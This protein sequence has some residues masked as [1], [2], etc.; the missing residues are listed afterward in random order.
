MEHH[1]NKVII[2]IRRFHF[3]ST[4]REIILKFDRVEEKSNNFYDVKHIYCEST[5]LNE[6]NDTYF[7]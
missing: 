6:C 4:V 5:F 1:T 3:S 7:L 2:K